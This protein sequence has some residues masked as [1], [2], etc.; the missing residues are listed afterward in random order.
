MQMVFDMFEAAGET[1]QRVGRQSGF[2]RPPRSIDDEG[3]AAAGD[4]SPLIP[5]VPVLAGSNAK[6]LEDEAE[7]LIT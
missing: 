4:R 1:L 2:L 3:N 7:Y 5:R 6:R